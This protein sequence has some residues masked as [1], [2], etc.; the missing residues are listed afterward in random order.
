MSEE[1]TALAALLT[2]LAPPLEFLAAD[3]FRQAARTILPLDAIRARVAAACAGAGDPALA[4]S[5]AELSEVIEQVASAAPED[6]GALLRR[7]HALLPGLQGAVEAR[8]AAPVDYA[9][10]DAELAPALAALAAPVE[11][12]PGVGP[13]RAPELARFGLATVEDLLYHLPFRYEDRRVVQ[14]VRELVV[15]CEASTEGEVAGV[16]QAV[17]GR[18]RRR[19][20]EVVLRDGPDVVLLVWFNQLGYFAQRFTPGQRLL[21]HGRVDPPL[22]NGPSRIVHPDVLV[23]GEDDAGAR[24]AVLPVYEKPTGMPVGVMRRLVHAAVDAHVARVPAALPVAVARRQ[25]VIEPAQALRYLHAPPNEANLDALNAARSLAHRSLAF[26]ELFFLQLGLA[27]RRSAAGRVRGTAFPPSVRLVPALRAALPFRATAAQDRTFAEIAR[28]LA[29][30][31]PM[32]RLLQG[33]VGSGKTLVGLLA[34]L[35]VVEHGHQA[36]F[37]A[38]TELLAEQHR[39]TIAPLVAPLGV[40]AELLTGAVRGRARRAVLAELARGEVAIVIGTQALIQE[41]V[42][43]QRLGL[44]VVDEQH[45]FGVMQRAALQRRD[46]ESGGLDVLVMSATPIPRTLALTLYGDLAVSTLDELPPGRTPIVT[47]VCRAGQR[48]RAHQR[49]RDEVARGHQAYVVYPLIDESEKSE[50]RAATTMVRELAAGPLAG[51]RL[52][53]LHGR[54]KAEEKDAVMRRFK[55]HEFDVLVSTT[56]IEVGIDV[57]NATVIVIEH[58]ERFG[59]AQL[60]QLRGR[61]GRGAARSHAVLVAPDWMHE[62]T[63]QRLRVLEQS[64][65]GF[66]IAEADLEL[67]GPGD[68]LGTR[69]AG[70]PPFRVANLVRDTAL[71]RAARDEALAWLAADPDL[72]RPESAAV[73][74][75]LAHRWAG[76][77][78]LAQ[79]G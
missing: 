19:L 73:R 67:R 45:R 51:L 66:R 71:M 56:V 1:R 10:S 63:F 30:P 59:L 38:P 53:L 4:R 77:L 29:E 49:L 57:P 2:A 50:L 35:T 14:R 54:M 8:G 52:A 44:A 6:R 58:A 65:D 41:G 37:M 28:D 15:G 74:A 32:R 25:R 61:V 31:H 70:L 33:D 47:E 79:V 24:A 11:R 21:V 34:A 64:T 20:L 78:E 48:E 16:R 60:H 13:K 55:A 5:L 76:R 40:R 62:E 26:D 12:V 68:F 43:F 18:G 69:Q 42:E 39:D 72:S 3:D 36:A 27:L 22:G 75:M 7:A 23:L 17:V 46:G 9:S